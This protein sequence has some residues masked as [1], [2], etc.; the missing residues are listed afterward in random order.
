MAALQSEAEKHHL[1]AGVLCL[2]FANTLYGHGKTPIH[3]YLADYRDLAIW[4]RRAGILSDLDLEA[5]LREA[6][7]RPAE[8]AAVFQRAI[9]LREMIHRIF[10]A[11]AHHER[12]KP[13]DLVALNAARNEAF[14]HSQIVPM[15]RGFSMGWMDPHALERMLWPIA[16]S[17]AELLTSADV[18][19]VRQCGGCDWLFVDT[20]RNHLRRWCSMSV[21]GNRAKVRRFIERKRQMARRR[22]K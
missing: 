11:V 20:S 3:E 9:A 19:R 8:A 2:N 21:C 17:A 5:L 15:P 18:D 13:A 4:S 7:R 1:I 14:S 10:N 16:L 6:S 12:P 22:S